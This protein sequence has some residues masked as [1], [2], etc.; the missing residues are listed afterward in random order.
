M[1]EGLTKAVADNDPSTLNATLTELFT[2]LDNATKEAEDLRAEMFHAKQQ[3]KS[4]GTEPPTGRSRTPLSKQRGVENIPMLVNREGF[5]T[6]TKKILSFLNDEPGMVDILKVI[7][8]DFGGEETITSSIVTEHIAKM[9]ELRDYP[10]ESL[11]RELHGLLVMKTE[12]TAWGFVDNCDGQGFDAWRVLH[13]EY[14]PITRR[15]KNRLL[16]KILFPTK[17]GRYDDIPRSETEWEQHI[18]KY[19]AV[20]S[21]NVDPDILLAAYENMLPEKLSEAIDALPDEITDLHKMK[22]YV[23]RQVHAKVHADVIAKAGSKDVNHVGGE[24]D[25]DPEVNQGEARDMLN[26]LFTSHDTLETLSNL[27]SLIKGGKGQG[28]D[29]AKGKGK[30]EPWCSHCWTPGHRLRECKEFDKVMEQR[31]A[32]TK[33]KGKGWQKGKGKDQYGKGWQSGGMNTQWGNKGSKGWGKTDP[34]RSGKGVNDFGDHSWVDQPVAQPT[35]SQWNDFAMNLDDWEPP[36]KPAKKVYKVT[37]DEMTE[38]STGRFNPLIDLDELDNN[39]DNWLNYDRLKHDKGIGN[40]LSTGESN[41]NDNNKDIG[42]KLC[43]GEPNSND[44][45]GNWLKYEWLKFDKDIALATSTPQAS[46]AATATHTTYDTNQQHCEHPKKFCNSEVYEMAKELNAEIIPPKWKRGETGT[47]IPRMN[48]KKVRFMSKCMSECCRIEDDCA[49]QRLNRMADEAIKELEMEGPVQKPQGR[50]RIPRCLHTC[51]H[52]RGVW[53]VCQAPCALP[54]GHRGRHECSHCG[55]AQ[56]TN[57]ETAVEEVGD[58]QVLMD[59]GDEHDEILAPMQTQMNKFTKITSV[60]DSGA[61]DN[62]MNSRVAPDVP[63][64]SSEGSR[65]GQN[66]SP[67]GGRPIPNEGEQLLSLRT[68]EGLAAPMKFQIAEVRRPLCSIAK[69]CDRNN[70]VIFG[71]GGG[72]VQNLNSGNC[73]PFRREGNVY[74]MDL[75]LDHD[76][77]FLGQS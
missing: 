22:E 13:R 59:D 72:I 65:R 25:S 67:A 11:N 29:G 71:R 5:T 14:E 36:K 40:K 38:L 37:T 50:R 44:N 10:V 42:N 57:T 8:R 28:K 75:W 18:A 46:P 20:T 24:V 53:G 64:Q 26:Q 69:L 51:E 12:G 73:T 49:E 55:G 1:V 9:P 68:A 33:A 2:D 52:E 41:S 15:G 39:T 74:T 35:E 6:F 61:C 76:R 45:T 48:K 7:L 63:I 34:W 23:R 31:R 4:S 21:K 66:Y 47:Q 70:R 16:K 54:R 30:G 27:M 60:M 32:E 17:A 62:V 43:T 19:R 56:M 77:P 58:V 3:G